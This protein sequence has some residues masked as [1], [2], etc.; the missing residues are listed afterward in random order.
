MR[1]WFGLEIDVVGLPPLIQVCPCL[2]T[3]FLIHEYVTYTYTLHSSDSLDYTSNHELRNRLDDWTLRGF[4]YN[5]IHCSI[6]I[7]ELK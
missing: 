7:N 2:K 6:I 5:R 1:M 3:G 4:S